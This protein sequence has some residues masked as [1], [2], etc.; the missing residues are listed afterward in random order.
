MMKDL[1][2]RLFSPLSMSLLALVL[3]LTP[4]P[5]ETTAP[6][7]VPPSS[8]V[9]KTRERWASPER[10][11]MALEGIETELVKIRQIIELQNKGAY[12]IEKRDG[13][14]VQIP[15]EGDVGHLLPATEEDYST[16]HD[17]LK[18]EKPFYE[19]MREQAEQDDLLIGNGG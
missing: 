13:K 5:E 11:A 14:V 2:S 19:I 1:F 15:V 6:D 4:V 12:V 16:M 9:G 3:V 8:S 10:Q 17:Y 7:S 18:P